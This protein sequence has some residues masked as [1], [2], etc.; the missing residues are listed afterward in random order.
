MKNIITAVAVLL[1]ATGC[2]GMLPKKYTITHP[3]WNEYSQVSTIAKHIRAGQTV[4]DLKNL[5]VNV[6]K[7]LTILNI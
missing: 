1:V 4:G 3:E 6:V 7:Q 5:G 2:T